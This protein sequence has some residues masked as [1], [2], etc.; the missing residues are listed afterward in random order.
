MTRFISFLLAAFCSPA[1][2]W[3]AI[4]AQV[5][6]SRALIC[7]CVRRKGQDLKQNRLVEKQP[8]GSRRSN[9]TLP[10]RILPLFFG[11][12]CKRTESF[13]LK[14][15]RWFHAS[16][17]REGEEVC[18]AV[19]LYLPQTFRKTSTHTSP[20]GFPGYRS[21]SHPSACNEAFLSSDCTKPILLLLAE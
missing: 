4:S 15:R 14:L 17:L 1:R 12:K 19:H 8:L 3:E 18:F 2:G 5:L 20:P 9:Y 11:P 21:S 16:A 10:R 13:P 6:E 7:R